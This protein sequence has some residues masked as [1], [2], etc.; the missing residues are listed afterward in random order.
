MSNGTLT[1]SL[2]LAT[3]AAALL[4]VPAAAQ[5]EKVLHS[6][7]KGDGDGK[8]PLSHILYNKGVLYGTT[9]KGG[10]YGFGTVFELKQTNRIWQETVLFNFP[11]KSDGAYPKAGLVIDASGALYGTT[12]SG[13][14]KD[15]GIVYR[16]YRAGNGWAEQVLHNFISGNDGSHP[17]ADLKIDPT[18]GNMY[19]TTYTGGASNCGVVYQLAQS[20]GTWVQ[21][22]IYSLGGS[23]GCN[24]QTGLKEDSLG[25]LYGT[26]VTGGQYGYGNVFVLISNN[27]AWNETIL[28]SFSSGSDGAYGSGIDINSAGI[29]YG[30]TSAG[31]SHGDGVVFA[32]TKSGG[33]WNETIL[34][35]FSGDPDGTTPYGIHVNS[36]T[37]ALFGTTETGG[38]TNHG[39][40]FELVPSGNTW[41]ES[42]LHSFNGKPDGEFPEAGLALDTK[43]STLYGTTAEGGTANL[44]S[45]FSLVP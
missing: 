41:T 43:G 23:A 5:S 6:F 26:T 7:T 21:S 22:V 40:L 15:D 20:G 17:V 9:E 32:L 35:D 37:G 33:E 16:L 44:G 19:G 27:G 36:S 30:V 10:A 29:I 38:S 2:A 42:V 14:S 13:G 1:K 28:H 4:A 24:S 11:G 18:S 45:V 3:V 12:E 39:C 8:T 34:H 25:N 31:G